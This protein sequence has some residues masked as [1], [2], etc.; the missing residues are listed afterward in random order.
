MQ[1]LILGIGDDN[2]WA[3]EPNSKNISFYALFY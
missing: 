1:Q 3:I 2:E